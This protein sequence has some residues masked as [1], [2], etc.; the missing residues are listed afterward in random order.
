MLCLI[1]IWSFNISRPKHEIKRNGKMLF[2]S[3]R[4]SL[5]AS[6]HPLRDNRDHSVICSDRTDSMFVSGI[7][8]GL[9]HWTRT[10]MFIF[11]CTAPRNLFQSLVSPRCQMISTRKLHFQHIF[12]TLTVP[13]GIAFKDLH[14][15]QDPLLGNTSRL[16][17]DPWQ[18]L[19]KEVHVVKI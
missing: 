4:I 14:S 16:P 17:K 5:L 7:Y 2:S 8:C 18:L 10:S 3:T 9:C 15:W 13:Y 11:S 19:D 6:L 1:A 12:V